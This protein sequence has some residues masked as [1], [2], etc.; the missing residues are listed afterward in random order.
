MFFVLDLAN[1]YVHVLGVTAHPSGAWTT[2]L[3]RNLISDLGGR[4]QQLRYLIRDRDA[5]FTD[6]FD[7]VPASEGIQPVKTPAQCPRAN[8]YVER[9]IRTVECTDRMLISSERHLRVVLNEYTAHYNSGRPHRSLQLQAPPPTTPTSSHRR[10]R[11]TR[12][13][14]ARSSEA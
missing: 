14:A 2:Q 5:K 13:G 10:S 4:V 6:T 1:R 8:A 11:P 12:S 7:T 3:A 9:W